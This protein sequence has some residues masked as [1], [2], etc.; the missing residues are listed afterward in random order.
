MPP[1]FAS[2]ACLARIINIPTV[3]Q[4]SKHLCARVALRYY[5]VLWQRSWCLLV[6]GQV[7]AALA[8]K[9]LPMPAHLWIQADNTAR[10]TRNQHLAKWACV[11]VMRNQFRS[12][13][14]GYFWVGHTK[15]DV[16]QRFSILASALNKQAV[17]ETPEDRGCYNPAGKQAVLEMSGHWETE[18]DSAPESLGPESD[19]NVRYCFTESRAL[20]PFLPFG[21]V[22]CKLY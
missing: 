13:S 1:K 9:N 4:L 22:P 20:H 2:R 8:K 12:V 7:Q 3:T 5:R 11:L 6:G 16:D 10:E 19:P 18:A 14:Y 17:L 21:C 15:N